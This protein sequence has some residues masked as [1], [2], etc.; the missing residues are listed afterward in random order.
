MGQPDDFRGG[1]GF[2]QGGDGGKSVHDVSERAES[3]DQEARLRHAEPCE[4]IREV[5]RGMIFGVA[6]DGD[7]DAEASGGG[8][9]GYGVGGVV[10]ALGVDVG[11]EIFQAEASTLGS[12]KRT[13]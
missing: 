4:R 2:A 10:G 13:T 6:D 12:L 11:A 9:L 7:A 8:A 1:K 5:A 3:Q